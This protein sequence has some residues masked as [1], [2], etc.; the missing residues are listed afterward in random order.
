MAETDIKQVRGE[1]ARLKGEVVRLGDQK[2]ALEEQVRLVRNESVG[3]TFGMA[4][5][6]S[7]GAELARINEDLTTKAV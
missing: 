2:A 6:D 4:R 5:L 7:A 1:P 3:C